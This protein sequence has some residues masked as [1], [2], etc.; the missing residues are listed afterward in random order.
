MIT[1]IDGRIV[2]ENSVEFNS[3]T[4]H[5]LLNGEDITDNIYRKDKE[6]FYGFDATKDNE[7]IYQEKYALAHGGKSAPPVGSTST[8]GNFWDQ[9]TSDPLQA[10]IETLNH[11][12]AKITGSSGVR[13][14][15]IAAVVVVVVILF[16]KIKK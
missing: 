6:N 16:V 15:T 11:T 14:L 12:V 10:P 1:L 2:D 9:M 8:L 13:T 5:F 3:G 4:Y 7:R